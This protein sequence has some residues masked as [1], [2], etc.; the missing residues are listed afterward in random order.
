MKQKFFTDKFMQALRR[1]YIVPCNLWVKEDEEFYAKNILP[2]FKRF[3]KDLLPR[4]KKCDSYINDN[5]NEI[6][7]TCKNREQFALP[8]GDYIEIGAVITQNRI[9]D[10]QSVAGMVFGFTS[11][12]IVLA[13]GIFGID[14]GKAMKILSYI[15]EE[16][17]K[18]D[19][20][21]FNE[22]FAESF[23]K[24][25]FCRSPKKGYQYE[26]NNG[27]V[28]NETFAGYD[29]QIPARFITDDILPD[30]VLAHYKG[31]KVVNRF[32]ER[33]LRPSKH[34]YEITV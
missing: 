1:S 17:E 2:P 9:T 24:N 15:D 25:G 11:K 26:D 23:G 10:G 5:L 16:K 34:A 7:I 20:L 30:I 14:N 18:Y 3:V 29:G 28:V 22:D 19:L 13:G 32:I 4:L 33:A 6:L 21:T 12:K 27:F 8:D 31:I